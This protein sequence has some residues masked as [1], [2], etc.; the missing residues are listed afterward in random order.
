MIVCIGF[1]NRNLN[2]RRVWGLWRKY[3]RKLILF[4][5]SVFVIWYI[6]CLPETL[7]SD[8]KSTVLLDTDGKLLNATIADDGQWRFTPCK[9][10]P[11]KI[12]ICLIE[13]EDRE[14]LSHRGV[15]FSSIGRALMQ[16]VSNKRVVSGASTISMQV[17]RLMEKNPPRTYT[18][19]LYEILLATRMELRYSKKEIL[20]MYASN[21]PFGG[22][23]VGLDAAAWRYFN[24]SPDQLSW[25]E[26]ATLAVLPN[27]PGLIHPGKNRDALIS[28]RNRLLKHLYKEGIIDKTEYELAIAESI[29]SKPVPLPQR[30]SH[31]LQKFIAEGRKGQTIESTLQLDLQSRVTRELNSHQQ[32]LAHNHIENGAVIIASVKTGEILSYVGNVNRSDG[33]HESFVNCA[34]A[35]RSSG[36]VLKPFLY[37]KSLEAGIITPKM[38]LPDVPS[39]FG[40]FTPVNYSETYDGYVHADDALARSLNIPFVH[41]L[42]NYGHGKFHRNLQ[43]YE[44][45]TINRSSRH[46]GLSLVLGGA[47]IS[48]ENLTNAY[49]RMA[50]EVNEGHSIGIHVEKDENIERIPAKTNPSALYEMFEGMTNLKRPG[51]DHHWEL[52]DSSRK[53]AW[54]TGTSFGFRD[55]WSIA[56]TPE[57]VVAVWVGNADGEGRPG[58][59]GFQAAAPLLFRIINQLPMKGEW[60]APPHE[61]QSSVNICSESGHRASELCPTKVKSIIPTSSLEKGACPYHQKI[62]VDPSGQFRVTDECVSVYEMKHPVWFI[63]PP[64]N[65]QY[66]QPHHPNYKDLP[67]WMDGC[68]VNNSHQSFYLRYPTKNAR[69]Q[70]S[71]DLN[72]E[73]GTIVLEASCRNKSSTIYWHL[74]DLFLGTTS[75]FH[76]MSASPEP[77]IHTLTL[78]DEFGATQ[79]VSFEVI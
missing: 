67:P 3:R 9:K 40:N 38:L 77:G 79:S 21:A 8:P 73:K 29:P 16:N 37:A 60:F 12:A 23:V 10:V 34:N 4:C 63:L 46:Y 50:Q 5:F 58:L 20:A 33:A 13:F 25:A 65:A 55:A 68:G 1:I 31:L 70:L 61:Y 30:A 44:F 74:D 43:Q 57:Y 41:L 47:E 27:A 69:I 2:F 6:D 62:H 45:E 52:F 35:P 14:F 51:S 19:K 71:R 59:T 26:S 24:R 32:F 72:G 36:S 49:T 64:L 39:K 28:K 18:Q 11:P 53:I 22:N 75:T 76:Q 78:V 17:I 56:I 42:N 48:L 15:N 66:Y 7:F 54:K